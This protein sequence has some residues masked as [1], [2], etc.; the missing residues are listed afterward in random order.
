MRMSPYQGG[1]T[2]GGGGGQEGKIDKRLK[3]TGR[4]KKGIKTL[5]RQKKEKGFVSRGT[6]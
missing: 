3:G 4:T 6:H 1:A 2:L 5:S